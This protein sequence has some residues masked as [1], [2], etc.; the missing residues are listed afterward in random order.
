MYNMD[1]RSK[2][3]IEGVQYFL[4]TAERHKHRGFMCCPCRE[5]KNEREYSS[6]APIHLHL[7]QRGFMPNYICWTKHGET[8]VLEVDEEEYDDTFSNYAQYSSF[9]D[10][11][12]DEVED[13]EDNDAMAQMLHDEEKDC[14]NEKVR[15]N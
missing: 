12:T 2:G 4:N 6:T 10:A 11:V 14:D 1:R 13:A 8:G 15:K 5:C 9:V 7:L 3:Y